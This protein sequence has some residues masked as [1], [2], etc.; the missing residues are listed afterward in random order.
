MCHLLGA[1]CGESGP[2]PG[3][4]PGAN[5]TATH[6]APRRGPTVAGPSRATRTPPRQLA[7]TPAEASESTTSGP[8][9]SERHIKSNGSE[10]AH[11]EPTHADYDALETHVGAP[12]DPILQLPRLRLTPPPLYLHTADRIPGSFFM[13]LML[14]PV[15]FRLAAAPPPA[16]HPSRLGCPARCLFAGRGRGV[17]REA[18][19][20]P[21]SKAQA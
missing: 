20:P 19:D 16:F 14:L 1:E 9:E 12:P 18:V 4:I 3:P 6:G 11:L 7:R 13:V 10:V 5:P 17:Q 8:C 2:P 21:S 15:P